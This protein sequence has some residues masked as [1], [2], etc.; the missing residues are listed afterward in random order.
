MIIRSCRR[1]KQIVSNNFNNVIF[2]QKCPKT[3]TNHDFKCSFIEHKTRLSRQDTHP[4]RKYS[5]MLNKTNPNADRKRTRRERR[6][7]RRTRSTFDSSSPESQPRHPQFLMPLFS[8][9]VENFSPVVIWSVGEKVPGPFQCFFQ[10]GCYLVV[11]WCT[12]GRGF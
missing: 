3:V 11:N 10:L 7:R 2:P 9:A 12:G 8:R 1:K 4:L 5:S 6:R